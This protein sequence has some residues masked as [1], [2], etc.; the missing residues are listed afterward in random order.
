LE[1]SV[2]AGGRDGWSLQNSDGTLRGMRS[3]FNPGGVD[4]LLS[5]DATPLWQMAVNAL[6]AV[7]E[8]DAATAALLGGLTPTNSDIT[9]LLLD[10][11][12]NLVVPVDGAVLPDLPPIDEAYTE[13]FELGWNGL[14]AGGRL[15]VTAD[16]YYTKKNDFVS[17]LITET[18]LLFLNEADIVTYLTPIVGAPTAAALGA[19]AAMI[20]LG[21]VSS[22]QVG[23]QGAD[24]IASYRN[25]AEDIDLW[26][27][28]F[29][30][31]ASL[32]NRRTLGG[33]YS[34][35]S[36]DYIPV[37]GF[38]PV[39]LNAPKDKGSL[40]LTFR[41]A[42]SGVNASGGVR[43]TSSFPAHSAEF[44]GTTCVTGGTGGLFEENC[45]DTYAIFDLN[46]E[47]EVPNMAAT[48]QLSINN[49]F[50]T[51]YRSFPGVPKISRFAMVRVRYE[52]F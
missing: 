23:A 4:Q 11:N 19:G 17:P 36:E 45:V 27:A 7:G 47:Y 40:S 46:A 29:T 24:L 52:L 13:T 2:T 41:D 20:P 14:L 42:L 22:D 21:V 37:A 35:I 5:A 25:V 1:F 28:D 12:T 44:R 31:Q 49:V 43:F 32:T 6:F 33:S 39:A 50:D 15:S 38:S 3:P 8:I 48:L 30:F 16:V 51:G 26:G 18:P 34:H 9:R 10:T